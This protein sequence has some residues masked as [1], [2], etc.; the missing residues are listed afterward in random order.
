[1]VLFQLALTILK[2]NQD[3][4]LQCHDDG[5]AIMILTSYLD[6][7]TDEDENEKK[8][9]RLIKQSYE[10]YNDINEE[11]INRLRLKHRL[12]VVQTMAESILQSAAKNTLKYTSFTEYEIK[13]LFYVF[14]D[15]SRISLTEAIDP[16]KLAY[17]TYRVGRSEYLV[18]CK[19]LSPWFI[20]EHPED[21]AKRLFD[22]Y[23]IS[24]NSNEIDFI[25]FIRLWNI[26][27]NEDFNDKLRLIFIAHIEEGKRRDKAISTLLEPITMY[28]VSKTSDNK[29]TEAAASTEQASTS[30]ESK[31]E[32]NLKIKL[33]L[34][35]L[36][37]QTEFIHLCKT[38]YDLMT[39]AA[40]DENLF[41]SL[42]TSSTILFK[43]GT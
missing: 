30:V 31:E 12:K 41:H 9:V 40:D 6:G 8:I 39:S 27:L 21:L 35:P 32:E 5:D 43:T 16:R 20:G 11:D 1:K 10:D 37:N 15:A 25:N 34:L 7:L 4:L 3:R 24:T 17:E 13:D 2:E 29:Q 22:V 33:S 18:L 23:S 28:P 42:T 38:M 14:K 19:Y 36:M 26:L